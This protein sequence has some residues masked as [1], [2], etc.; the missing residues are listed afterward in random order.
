MQVLEHAHALEDG[1]PLGH[2]ADAERHDLVR[3]SADDIAALEGD[4]P[5]RRTDQTGDGLEQRGL[6]GAIG[7][8]QG[9]DLPR[10]DF[11]PHVV[12]HLDLAVAHAQP[13]DRQHG[14]GFTSSPR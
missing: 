10:R 4:R 9:N 3:G 7:A 12:Q 14:H 8:D 2:M 11:E 6:A 5:G 1:A 13:L